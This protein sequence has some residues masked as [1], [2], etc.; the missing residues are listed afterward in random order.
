[1]TEFDG[2]YVL[3]D[4]ELTIPGASPVCSFC[5]RRTF[6]DI[7]RSCEAFPDG[8]P[9]PIWL[10]ENGHSVSYPGDGGLQFVRAD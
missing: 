2:D 1:M 9:L 4:S 8:I 7:P 6:T 5:A 10:G 3:D